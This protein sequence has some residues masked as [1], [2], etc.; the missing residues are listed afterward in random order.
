[1]KKIVFLFVL[2]C[3]FICFSCSN[4]PS[5]YVLEFSKLDSSQKEQIRGEIDSLIT[6]SGAI[7]ADSIN[8]YEADSILEPFVVRGRAF[9]QEVM[10][11]AQ[12][13][14]MA[15]VIPT[16]DIAIVA[17]LTDYELALATVAVDVWLGNVE[18]YD[19]TGSLEVVDDILPCLIAASGLAE[20]AE[21][22]TE[23]LTIRVA[24][25]LLKQV[26]RRSVG[27]AI[28][29]AIIVLSFLDCIYN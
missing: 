14:A 8:V 25:R 23:P 13:P 19:P 26:A 5:D 7:N 20:I 4:E 2:S 29:V 1:M 17:S 9:Q 10:R 22:V 3:A 12:A 18:P 6:R 21:L 11:A 15:G 16:T 27:G 28:E 24:I